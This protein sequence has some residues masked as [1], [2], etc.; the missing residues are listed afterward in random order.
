MIS[1]L[2]DHGTLVVYSE[3]AAASRSVY[4][5]CDLQKSIATAASDGQIKV[6]T[7]YVLSL[8]SY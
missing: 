7:R 4:G 6:S 1:V 2:I 3:A 8:F 5:L